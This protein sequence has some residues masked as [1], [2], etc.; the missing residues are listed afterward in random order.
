[1]KRLLGLGQS[2]AEVSARV[3]DQELANLHQGYRHILTRD[4]KSCRLL[5]SYRTGNRTS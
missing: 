1:M 4:V 5:R 3:T 2:C